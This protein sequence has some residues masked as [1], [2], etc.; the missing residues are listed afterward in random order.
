MATQNM[1]E[2]RRD[3]ILRRVRWDVISGGVAFAAMNRADDH[4]PFGVV[5]KGAPGSSL[6][7]DAAKVIKVGPFGEYQ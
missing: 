6:R 2:G 7:T 5:E 1:R 3:S 4:G